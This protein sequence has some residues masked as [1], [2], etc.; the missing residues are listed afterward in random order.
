MY[1][2]ID[3]NLLY[4]RIMQGVYYIK[5]VNVS[6]HR[7]KSLY[8]CKSLFKW[9]YFSKLVLRRKKCFEMGKLGTLQRM[10]SKIKI[11]DIAEYTQVKIIPSVNFN[12][13]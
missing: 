13:L 3:R 9:I 7:L 6:S 11:A 8:G 4:M 5:Y 10:F 2:V 12:L 1:I